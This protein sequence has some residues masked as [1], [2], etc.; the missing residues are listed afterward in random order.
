M[1]I[2][3]M[4]QWMNKL[5]DH[6]EKFRLAYPKDNLIIV[7]D[8]DGTILDM[9][10]LI[11]YVL[12]KFDVFLGTKYFQ[13]VD[14]RDINFHED[15]V[16]SML[17]RLPIC[18]SHRKTI[19]ALFGEHPILATAFPHSQR[20]FHGALDVVR[21][22]QKQPNTFVGLNTGRPESLRTNTLKTL[23]AWGR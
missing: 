18:V 19:L 15:H 20:P 11:L 9:R 6:Y 22:F 21:W 2:T 16:L 17:E 4:N 14:F 8:I 13:D 3:G 7:F 12:K 1:E 10:H 5:A 23:N